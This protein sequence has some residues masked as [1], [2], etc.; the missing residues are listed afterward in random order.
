MIAQ[1]K[2][3]K[4]RMLLLGAAL[5][6][7]CGCYDPT[8]SDETRCGGGSECP[9]GRTCRGGFCVLPGGAA[10]A[11]TLA[12]DAPLAADAAGAP[13]APPAD[14][15]ARDA[16]PSDAR[17]DAPG[18]TVHISVTK[19]GSGTLQTSGG[20]CGFDLRRAGARRAARHADAGDRGP[21]RA[22]VLLP[23]LGRRVQRQPPRVHADPHRGPERDGAV[24]AHRHEPDL[25][26]VD[27]GTRFFPGAGNAVDSVCI[28]RAAD[29]GLQG[30]FRAL[31]S[32]GAPGLT[33]R[34]RLASNT[35]RFAAASAPRR[36]DCR[37][38]RDRFGRD[39]R[40]R[41]A[42]RFDENGR[43]L[44]NVFAWTRG[45]RRQPPHRPVV[46][47]VDP[48]E[49]QRLRR[50]RQR[51]AAA[52]VRLRAVLRDTGAGPVRDGPPR[53]HGPV[54]AGAA[55]RREARASCAGHGAR[56][57]RAALP[58]PRPARQRA[59]GLARAARRRPPRPP[60]I[61]LEPCAGYYRPD[62]L[63]LGTGA[64]LR[65]PGPRA[66]SGSAPTGSPAAQGRRTVIP[67]G[68]DLAATPESNC[69]DWSSSTGNGIVG[70]TSGDDTWW[71][72]FIVA[73]SCASEA[74]VYCVD[75]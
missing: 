68:L 40:V 4:R 58:A 21:A 51:R 45:V 28:A 66:A 14:A 20:I 74:A 62:G 12:P 32:T 37:R 30:T 48:A 57:Q 34:L 73:P 27:G 13:D 64:E 7:A 61:K 50:G 26:L 29:A 46:R 43:A 11:P 63:F 53:G 47:G 56:E 19:Q 75:P 35:T 24:R 39:D 18:P 49:R 60:P 15:A 25:R 59:R 23:A 69:S 5:A 72:S 54:A 17:P 70:A 36:R 42:V 55:P 31:A 71:L 10:D 6:F 16:A 33:E 65:N 8:F 67:Q 52:G 38:Q 3:A 22:G 41:H 1:M 44:S 2:G 9:T